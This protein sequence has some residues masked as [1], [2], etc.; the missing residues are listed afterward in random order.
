MGIPCNP[1][2]GPGPSAPTNECCLL[3][4][5]SSILLLAISPNTPTL[6]NDSGLGS[7]LISPSYVYA[8]C[9][10]NRNSGVIEIRVFLGYKSAFT[11]S[12]PC[13][14]PCF[15]PHVL[16]QYLSFIILVHVPSSCSAYILSKPDC[17]N[18]HFCALIWVRSMKGW[19]LTNRWFLIRRFLE[20]N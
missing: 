13:W 4:R 15:N 1:Q 2:G 7:H 16:S 9:F 20:A 11:T 19:I 5:R 12:C 6:A 14:F 3:G 18:S 8:A 10:C 17:S